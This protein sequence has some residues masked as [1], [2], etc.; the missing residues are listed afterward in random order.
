LTDPTFAV[1]SAINGATFKHGL[2]PIAHT[3]NVSKMEETATDKAKIEVLPVY[4]SGPS[5]GWQR[6]SI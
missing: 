1:G 2:N 6:R 5:F 3:K 4:V